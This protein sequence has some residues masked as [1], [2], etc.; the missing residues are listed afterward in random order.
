MR[1][2]VTYLLHESKKNYFCKLN[3][4]NAKEFWKMM[5]LFNQKAPPTKMANKPIKV[6]VLEGDFA[7]LPALGFPLALSLQL[8]QSCLRLTDAM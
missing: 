4:V 7:S 6:V 3:Q 8:Q 5:K 1:N 2:N